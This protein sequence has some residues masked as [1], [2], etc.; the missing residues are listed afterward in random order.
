MMPTSLTRHHFQFAQMA[1]KGQQRDYEKA[2]GLVGH[3][4]DLRNVTTGGEYI[5]SVYTKQYRHNK[6]LGK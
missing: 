4:G 3:L 6:A 5:H 2:A 1:G